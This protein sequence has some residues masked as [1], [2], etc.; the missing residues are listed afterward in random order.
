MDV[1]TV[2][3]RWAWGM[4]RDLRRDG[5]ILRLNTNIFESFHSETH[6]STMYN[7]MR[8][9]DASESI[10]LSVAMTEKNA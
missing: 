1:A 9:D 2:L 8:R 7:S 6:E 3:L 10:K 5:A 4:Q